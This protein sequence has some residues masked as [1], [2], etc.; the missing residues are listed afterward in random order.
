M[1]DEAHFHVNGN[2]NK[3]NMRYWAPA[4]PRQLHQRPLHDPKVRVWCTVKATKLIGPYFFEDNNGETPTVNSHRYRNMN[5]TF[6]V[7]EIQ[8]NDGLWFQQDGATVYTAVISM[9]ELQKL[10]Q[11]CLISRFRDVTWLCH[12]ADLT[13]PDYFLW[14]HSM[15]TGVT[16]VLQYQCLK[17]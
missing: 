10:F 3:Q 6:L 15:V 12:S 5:Q 1:S 8:D 17:L 7:P 2:V 11:R 13:A 9:T 4:N 16:L 14:G